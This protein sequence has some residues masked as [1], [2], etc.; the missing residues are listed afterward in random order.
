MNRVAVVLLAMSLAL[1]AYGCKKGDE[2]GASKKGEAEKQETVKKAA[3][4]PAKAEEPAAEKKAEQPAVE[5]KKAEEP[6][7]A[8]KADAPSAEPDK[9]TQPDVDKEPVIKEE[10]APAVAEDK[11]VVAVP[12]EA[13]AGDAE[14]VDKACTHAI[15]LMTKE[16]GQA[17]PEDVAPKIKTECMADL[18][19]R[20]N[21]QEVAACLLKAEAVS[22]FGECLQP[23]GVPTPPDPG[24][25]AAP[26]AGP[27]DPVHEKACTHAITVM[28][29]EF[30]DKIPADAMDGAM[31]ECLKEL[32]ARP[33]EQSAVMAAC[34]LKGTSSADFGQCA[35]DGGPDKTKKEVPAP[36][37]S[38]KKTPPEE[39]APAPPADEPVKE[40]E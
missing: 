14:L 33:A 18:N 26:P 35:P 6:A 15:E 1:A 30:K 31:G 20:A 29:E 25:G 4:V 27:V 38:D 32:A 19:G 7:P 3:E 11:E 10:P 24:K 23:A 9:A 5:D 2:E 8:D 28:K 34:L 37:V 16:M 12:A 13:P 39:E 36:E 21:S 17:P 40:A 22:A